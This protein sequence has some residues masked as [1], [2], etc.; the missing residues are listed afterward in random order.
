MSNITKGREELL[1][2]FLT[3]I[4]LLKLYTTEELI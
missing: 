4:Y 2:L 1:F 3:P